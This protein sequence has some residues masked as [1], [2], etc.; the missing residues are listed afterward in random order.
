MV[1]DIVKPAPEPADPDADGTLRACP[2]D[3]AP[4]TPVTP[5]TQV[6]AGGLESLSDLIKQDEETSYILVTLGFCYDDHR[7]QAGRIA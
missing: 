1:R 7:K 6:S 2:Q 4:Q 3:R 5:V